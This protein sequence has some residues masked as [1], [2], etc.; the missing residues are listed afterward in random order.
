MKRPCV[1][2]PKPARSRIYVS[3][4][5][6]VK[7][8]ANIFWEKRIALMVKSVTDGNLVGIMSERDFVKALRPARRT[9]RPSAT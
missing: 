5:D 3:D 2:K 8:C 7:D 9:P 6:S 1:V 4:T